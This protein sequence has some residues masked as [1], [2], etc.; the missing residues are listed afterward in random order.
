MYDIPK[1][2]GRSL[3]DKIVVGF[4]VSYIILGIGFWITI[5]LATFAFFGAIT[6]RGWFLLGWN[7]MDPLWLHTLKYGLRLYVV[8][9]PLLVIM[10]I[11]IGVYIWLFEAKAQVWMM[12]L[13]T[14]G[15]S[16]I[17]AL[18]LIVLFAFSMGG[19]WEVIGFLPY[20]SYYSYYLILI[21]LFYTIFVVY[22]TAIVAFS[23]PTP[24]DIANE[25][26]RN[27]AFWILFSGFFVI[28][29]ITLVPFVDSLITE[30]WQYL[31]VDVYSSIWRA[32][33]TMAS[34]PVAFVLPVFPLLFSS[35][36][37]YTKFVNSKPLV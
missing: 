22:L 25:I 35:L 30:S 14:I 16:L 11:S 24:T 10:G 12:L 34:L 27:P 9:I 29:I 23:S 13:K 5:Q 28:L 37:Y 15:V 7:P 21:G 19:F 8:M 3:N 2:P 32:G 36:G 26:L 1:K 17:F 4:A 33:I 31:S 18:P 6:Q 20:L